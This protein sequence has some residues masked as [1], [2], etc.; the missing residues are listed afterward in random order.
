MYL[1]NY[2]SL[3]T[4][5]V[6]THLNTNADG[7]C[8]SESDCVTVR[9]YGGSLVDLRNLAD[10]DTI[11]KIWISETASYATFGAAGVS[12]FKFI[13]KSYTF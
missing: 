11:N 2:A 8:V 5:E 3:L 10:D 4:N 7:T 1:S 6:Q 9:E 12:L 13:F